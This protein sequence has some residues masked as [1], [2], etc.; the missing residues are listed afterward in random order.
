MLEKIH[1]SIRGALLV[2]CLV[3]IASLTAVAASYMYLDSVNEKENKAKRS[4]FV[5]KNKIGQAKENNRLI[6]LYE[7]PYLD[8]IDNNVVGEE[9]RLSWF[10]TLQS[11]AS[12]RGLDV[13]RFST[14][15]QVQVKPKALKREYKNIDI[16]KSVMILDM[17]I[18]HE[19]DIFAVF[20]DLESYA[21][22]LYSVDNCQIENPVSR[23]NVT[24]EGG[25][26]LSASCE[27][28]WH[29]IRTDKNDG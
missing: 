21:K 27:L 18:S 5:W 17:K 28:S 3:F 13:F 16:Y 23:N 15:S 1:H 10:E 19:G 7:K 14:A 11:T 26:E 8:L 22:G 6:V 2:F 20:N 25:G 12:S 4:A 24:T 9:N 29:T